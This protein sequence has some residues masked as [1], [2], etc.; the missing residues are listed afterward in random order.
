M[1]SR[2]EITWCLVGWKQPS[3]MTQPNKC[4]LTGF[5]KLLCK[6]VIDSFIVIS[7]FVKQPMLTSVGLLAAATSAPAGFITCSGTLGL[8][9]PTFDRQSACLV[10]PGAV[11]R[12]L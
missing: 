7:N 1:M 8:S 10:T 2:A 9:S 3:M 6:V 5:W 11:E 4:T 12:S